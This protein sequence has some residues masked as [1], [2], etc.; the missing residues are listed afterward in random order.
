ME[1]DSLASRL[2]RAANT[3]IAPKTCNVS[4]TLTPAFDVAISDEAP[5]VLTDAER[6]AAKA[7]AL[8]VGPT[9]RRPR[10]VAELVQDIEAWV[11]NDAQRLRRV[12]AVALAFVALDHPRILRVLGI[13]VDGNGP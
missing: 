2:R 4:V 7:A 9:P 10:P 13:P 6:Q 5:H 11:G 12:A 3:A 1:R 8:A